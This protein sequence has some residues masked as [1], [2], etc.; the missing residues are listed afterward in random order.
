MI[1]GGKM[2]GTR[3]K[4]KVDD[5]EF[6]AY[7]A[8]PQKGRG[9]G[10]VVIQEIFGVNQVMRDICDRLAAA[11]FCAICPDL[12]WRQQPGIDIT[13]KTEAEWQKAFAL[14]KGFNVDKGIADIGAT[15]DQFKAMKGVAERVGAVGYCLGG[16]LAFLT[17]ARTKADACVGYYGV[18]IENY[19][20]EARKINKPLMLHIAEK[21]SYCKPDAQAKIKTAVGAIKNAELHSYAG[22]E[23]AFA[24][25]GGQHFDKAA[26]S[27]A[28]AR[29]L[30]FFKD[31]LT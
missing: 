17:A 7:L 18:G 25:P 11:G 1:G 5:G 31:N 9:P 20:A 26:A 27:F 30:K 12:F 2:A 22:I 4:I 13:D 8:K 14:Y 19:L 21:D 16:L 23:H 6:D 15:I 29:T 3:V 24:R 10:V 28:D